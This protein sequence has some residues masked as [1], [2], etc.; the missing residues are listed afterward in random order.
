MEKYSA[1]LNSSHSFNLGSVS[2]HFFF[3]LIKEQF[4]RNS[5]YCS[6]LVLWPR[7]ADCRIS[8]VAGGS[9]F[10][11]KHCT[12]F[13]NLSICASSKIETTHYKMLVSIFTRT[14]LRAI[15]NDIICELSLHRQLSRN[16]YNGRALC[17]H[18]RF[19]GTENQTL[20]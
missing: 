7:S 13:H 4:K 10:E 16:F 1:S 20:T 18:V 2:T 9:H 19:I 6:F 8:A 17:L 11:N 14:C 12:R 5:I 15:S 3:L